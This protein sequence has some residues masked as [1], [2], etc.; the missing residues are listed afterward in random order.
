MKIIITEGRLN[1]VVLNWLDNEFGNLTKLVKNNSIQ[2]VNQDGLPLFY[3]FLDD[4]NK[5]VYINHKRIW[6][7]LWSIFGMKQEQIRE[8]LKIWL[9]ETYNLKGYAP[10]TIAH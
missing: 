1:S 6:S 4:S 2:Y 5:I 3:Y 7:L 9:E 8:I 10:I